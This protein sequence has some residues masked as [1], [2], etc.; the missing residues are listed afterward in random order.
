M[1][2]GHEAVI[3]LPYGRYKGRYAMKSKSL[4][5]VTTILIVLVALFLPPGRVAET[6]PS[7]APD[8]SREPFPLGEP[9]Y[10]SGWAW[11]TAGSP[12]TLNHNLGGDRDDYVVDLI[13]RRLEGAHHLSYGADWV[14]D[15]PKGAYWYDLTT[16]Q[17]RVLRVAGDNYVVQVRVRIWVVPHADADSG[18]HAIEFPEFLE[19]H[20][21]LGGNTDDY[22]VYL[23]AKNAAGVHHLFYGSQYSRDDVG[24]LRGRGFSWCLLTSERITVRRP[25]SDLAADQ[26]RVRIWRVPQADYDSG[27]I[28]IDQGQF[29]TLEHGLG[30][31]FGDFV[32]D[33]QFKA[34]YF[35]GINQLS[36]GLDTYL[37]SDR[38]SV[39][40]E[41]GATWYDLSGGFIRVTRGF[42]DDRADQVRVRIWLPWRVYLPLIFKNY[43]P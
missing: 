6:A 28:P 8:L 16:T 43:G 19:F 38:S 13:F 27:W 35:F 10:D 23:E 4:F 22:L 12:L 20:H 1:R 36:Y 3:R 40:G 42:S 39:Q 30:G 37:T 2:Q 41:M 5:A 7:R 25:P 32:V 11:I 33:L 18:W 17:I 31:P 14:G 15:D 21:D 9:A 34:T 29:L 26:V 24:N